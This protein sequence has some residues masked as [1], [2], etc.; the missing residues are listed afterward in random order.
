MRGRRWL[1]RNSAGCRKSSAGFW[2][3]GA[4]ISIPLTNSSAPTSSPPCRTPLASRIWIGRRRGSRDAI[5]AD[6]KIAIF[7]DYDVDGATSSAILYRYLAQ[8]HE[9]PRIYI[10]DRQVE[11]Y[12]PNAPA[13]RRLREEGADVVVT[14]DCGIMAFDALA[15]G[16]EAGLDVIVLDHHQ[17]EPQL[18]VAHAVVNPNRLDDDFPH[19]NLAAVGVAFLL[20]VAL[21]RELRRRGAFADRREPDLLRW[22]D[23]VALGT[24][25]DVVPLTGLN[26]VLVAQGLR[27][28]ARRE[29]PGLMALADVARMDSKPGAFHLGFLLGPRVNAGGRVGRSDLGA[30]LLTTESSAE[31]ARIGGGT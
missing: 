31:A 29:N 11:G 3:R 14:V 26:R 1:F 13:L 17:A 2:R 6:Q 19:R 27:V 9:P 7:G 22:L 30:R 15:A 5:A 25:A 18:P 4:S 16:A 10:P 23:L 24:V 28:L 8:V 21:N 20:L 12:G